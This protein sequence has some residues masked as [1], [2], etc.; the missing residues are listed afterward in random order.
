[1]FALVVSC[2]LW[3][4]NLRSLSQ[5]DWPRLF[6]DNQSCWISTDHNSRPLC[7]VDTLFNTMEQHLSRLLLMVGAGQLIKQQEQDEHAKTNRKHLVTM[8]QNSQTF[9]FN[10]RGGSDVVRFVCFSAGLK[11]THWTDFHETWWNFA[12]ANR[13]RIKVLNIW[14]IDVFLMSHSYYM[15]LASLCL[16]FVP[17]CCAGDQVLLYTLYVTNK[18]PL[19][20]VST[21]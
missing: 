3:S 16:G 5:R 6:L 4:K 9:Y 10:L 2:C 19:P 1:M 21:E 17:R 8:T 18:V 13:Y 20:L 7:A 15:V 11:K 12:G 14:I